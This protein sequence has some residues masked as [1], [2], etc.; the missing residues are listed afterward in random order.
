MVRERKKEEIKKKE[1]EDGG[2]GWGNATSRLLRE[3]REGEREREL[4]VVEIKASDW[5]I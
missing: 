2:G 3:S 5:P 4:R 1:E